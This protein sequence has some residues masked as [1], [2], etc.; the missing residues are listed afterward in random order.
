VC[1]S[2]QQATDCANAFNAATCTSLPPGCQFLD[3]ADPAP[4]VAACQQFIDETCVAQVRCEP[5]ATSETCHQ[6]A[7]AKVDCTKVVG[8]KLS[9]EQCISELKTVACSA[10]AAPASCVGALVSGA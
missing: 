1:K 10:T 3:L 4:A 8:V 2:D 7:S 9:F 6:Q 5:G